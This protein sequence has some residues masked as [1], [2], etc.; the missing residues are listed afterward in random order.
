[1]SDTPVTPE[2]VEQNMAPGHAEVASLAEAPIIRAPHEYSAPPES[3]TPADIPATVAEHAQAPELIRIGN[4]TFTDPQEA[5]AY[6]EK[7]EQEKAV[8]EAYNQGMTEV[9]GRTA[10]QQQV[11][12]QDPEP[13]DNLDEFYADPAKFLRSRYNRDTISI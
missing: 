2:Q 6:A 4:Q 13:E 9:V 1:M 5:Y 7:L 10:P 8:L 3:A 12:Q 11:T